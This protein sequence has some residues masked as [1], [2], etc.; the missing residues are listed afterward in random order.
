MK[1]LLNCE[2]RLK[3]LWAQQAQPKLK[4]FG[5]GMGG[6]A[7][8]VALGGPQRKTATSPPLEEEEEEDAPTLPLH[9][10]MDS[11]AAAASAAQPTVA[12]EAAEVQRWGK[13]RIVT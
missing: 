1:P 3:S 10:L 2:P 13:S 12:R 4:R 8:R 6:P 7:R 11:A 9:Q 5:L